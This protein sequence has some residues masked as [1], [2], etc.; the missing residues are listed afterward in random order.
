MNKCGAVFP[1]PVTDEPSA[2]IDTGIVVF[3]PKAAAALREL[4]QQELSCCCWDGLQGMWERHKLSSTGD[5]NPSSI[6]DFAHAH[7]MK[8][9]LYTHMMMALATHSSETSTL[10]EYLRRHND[11]PEN[12]LTG[13]YQRLSPFQLQTLLVPDGQFLHLGTSKELVQFLVQGT[14]DLQGDGVPSP[15]ALRTRLIADDMQLASE[16]Q[17]LLV[18][19]PYLNPSTTNHHMCCYNS[20]IQTTGKLQIG[21]GC[22][23]EHVHVQHGTVD[24]CIGEGCLISGWRGDLGSTPSKSNIVIPS[25]TCLQVIPLVEEQ[26]FVIMVFGLEDNI[27]DWHKVHGVDAGVFLQMTG[28]DDLWDSQEKQM[29]WTAKLHPVVTEIDL[30]ELFAWVQELQETG[31]IIQCTASLNFYKSHRRLSLEQIRRLSDAQKNGIIVMT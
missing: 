18:P 24:I 6:D 23:L 10:E 17:S 13:I 11:L 25:K 16:Y 9:D 29:L 31:E 27:K 14:R 15:D 5:E 22:V 19:S 2:W 20:L 8:V 12:I 26:K 4:A 7:A 30:P 21:Q 3:L 1:H 28:M